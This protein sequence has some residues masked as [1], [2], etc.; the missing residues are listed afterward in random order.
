MY[1]WTKKG[2]DDYREKWPDKPCK[3]LAG[4][5]IEYCGS[6][7]VPGSIVEAYAQRG[8]VETAEPVVLETRG[9][10]GR[11]KTKTDRVYERRW[12]NLQSLLKL[13]GLKSIKDL[14]QR[15]GFCEGAALTNF[16]RRHGE[17][18][19]SEYGKLPHFETRQELSDA[20][21]RVMEL[22]Q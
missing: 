18:L 21:M 10:K 13:D 6:T 3:R 1:V 11:T 15:L 7:R 8:W 19:V 16:V 5:E 4:Q 17:E 22:P 9:G 14:A 2:E 12:K 20:W